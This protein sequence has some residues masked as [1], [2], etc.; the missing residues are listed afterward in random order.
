MTTEDRRNVQSWSE[1][2]AGGV[3]A[4]KLDEG[5]EPSLR[6]RGQTG[7]RPDAAFRIEHERRLTRQKEVRRD[8]EPPCDPHK[9]IKRR[10]RR[11]ALNPRHMLMGNAELEPELRLGEAELLPSCSDSFADLHTDKAHSR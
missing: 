7:V 3:I 8:T 10:S 6:L 4:H 5:D 2:A 9:Q 1:L 11:T